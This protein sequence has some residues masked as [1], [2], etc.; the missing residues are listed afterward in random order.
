MVPAFEDWAFLAAA[1]KEL[2]RSVIAVDMIL[3]IK[4]YKVKLKL[5]KFQD[6]AFWVK[7]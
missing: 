6:I 1:F 7:S 4:A 5:L 3:I 2:Q